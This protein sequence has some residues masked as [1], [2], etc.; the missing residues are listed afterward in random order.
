MCE[1][2]GVM[3]LLSHAGKQQPIHSLQSG[4]GPL[5]LLVIQTLGEEEGEGG[6]GEEEERGRGEEEEEKP[7]S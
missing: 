1:E 7:V 6:K 2:G 3:Y 5:L 4:D